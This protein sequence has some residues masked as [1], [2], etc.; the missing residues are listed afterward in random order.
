M[1]NP[2]ISLIIPVY[3]VEP[4]ISK[5]M[6]SILSQTYRNLEII[7]ID[8]GSPDACGRICDEYAGKDSRIRVIHKENAG[9][10]AARNS[11]LEQCNGQYIMFV[12]SDDFLDCDAI[13]ILLE[14][15]VLC[16]SQMAVGK[17]I[18]AYEDGTYSA[19][20]CPWTENE[21][22]TPDDFFARMDGNGKFPVSAWGKLYS[23]ELF[24]G[25]C[26]PAWRCGEDL[27]VVTQ[28]AQRCNRIS[29]VDYTVYFYLQRKDSVV[30]K[31]TEAVKRD[32][33]DATL[34]VVQFLL[35]KG[36][37]NT[38]RNWYHRSVKRAL[39][40][41]D[42]AVALDLFQKHLDK[43]QETALLTGAAWKER[44]RW[45]SLH[46]GAVDALRRLVKQMIKRG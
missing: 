45:L 38:A 21:L 19:Q 16:G 15:M 46:S 36:Y 25:I 24:D 35:Q 29:L 14:R 32:E 12:D 42:R 39:E 37:D 40:F 34:T 26:F 18:D 2:L 30:H 23:R 6:E 27:W 44:V 4:F 11:G 13:R 20:V 10:S 31:K 1:N 9:V 7:L 5:C 8:D 3:K 22:L 17:H 41:A 33:L 28:V 43:N